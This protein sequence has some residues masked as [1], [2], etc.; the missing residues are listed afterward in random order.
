MS[1]SISKNAY[2]LKFPSLRNNVHSCDIL[3]EANIIMIIN[4][5]KLAKLI[6]PKIY[7]FPLKFKTWRTL[8]TP[9]TLRVF[10]LGFGVTFTMGCIYGIED[11]AIRNLRSLLNRQISNLK[12]EYGQTTV[13]P[14]IK[15]EL[16]GNTYEII[17]Q[18]DQRKCDLFSLISTFMNVYHTDKSF[19]VIDM[20]VFT[21]PKNDL[22][23]FY[24]DFEE[25]DPKF[26]SN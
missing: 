19:K 25:N 18:I 1:Q 6:I 9:R 23:T 24:V 3:S 5:F 2:L 20:K 4:T 14:Q 15:Y 7:T 21:N 12:N 17:F 13:Y 10:L 26:K 16:R 22:V 11:D 8:N